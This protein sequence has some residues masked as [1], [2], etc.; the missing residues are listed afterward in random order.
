MKN[1][2]TY[3]IYA[4]VSLVVVLL[5]YNQYGSAKR[6]PTGKSIKTLNTK[7][8]N[9][10]QEQ[11]DVNRSFGYLWDIKDQEKKKSDSNTTQDIKETNSTEL[12]VTQEKNKI[13]VEKNCYRFLGFYYK[14]GIPFISFYSKVFPKGLEDFKLHQILDNTIYIKDIKNTKLL[15]ADKNSSREWQFQLFDVNV[16]KYKP[17]DSNETNI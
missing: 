8:V 7:T 10:Y 9:I 3:S 14:A 4:F 6:T 5:V 15:L 1:K 17:K 2:F 12:A 16:T 11:F 13:C